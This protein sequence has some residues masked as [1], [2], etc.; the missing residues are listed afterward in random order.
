MPTRSKHSV[1]RNIFDR[2]SAMTE[3]QVGSSEVLDEPR[4][5]DNKHFRRFV[6][7]VATRK[8]QILERL[9]LDEES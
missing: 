1:Q 4:Q 3:H 2:F 5:K 7:L 9:L 6:R 8:Q